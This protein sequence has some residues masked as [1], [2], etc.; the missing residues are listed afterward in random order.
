[1]S[2]FVIC[3]SVGWSGRYVSRKMCYSRKKICIVYVLIRSETSPISPSVRLSVGWPI[4]VLAFFIQL[5]MY[6]TL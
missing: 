2:P 4:K 5:F 6:C 3:W 1:M